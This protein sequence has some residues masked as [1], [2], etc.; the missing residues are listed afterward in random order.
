M[1][2][3]LLYLARIV[4]VSMVAFIGGAIAQHRIDAKAITRIEAACAVDQD[5]GTDCGEWKFEARG[6][7]EAAGT[8]EYAARMC[9]YKL[10]HP[11]KKGRK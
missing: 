9:T 8:W 5:A 11:D 10:E 7:K 6:W 2:E 1:R 4:G 3:A